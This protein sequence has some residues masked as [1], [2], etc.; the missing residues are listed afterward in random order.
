MY[1]YSTMRPQP[2]FFQPTRCSCTRQPM[3]QPFNNGTVQPHWHCSSINHK[4]NMGIR[5]YGKKPF[6][7][8]IEAVTEKNCTFRT[9]L[10]T[11]EKL[12]VTLMNILPGEAIGLEIHPEV[13]QFLRIEVGH[14]LVQM[15]NTK[16]NL[17]FER[18]VYE[19]DAI[20]VPAGTWHN[21][22]NIGNI[23]LKL[24]TIYAPPEHPFGTV[25]QTKADAL[26]TGESY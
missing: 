13:D 25:H 26:E 18:L 23:P 11:G 8:N 10:W 2:C 22:T 21:L 7:V 20:M 16:N 3:Y 6:V 15:G 4:D 1:Y 9:T 17:S 24:Y 5:D 19:D 14:G 12:Q